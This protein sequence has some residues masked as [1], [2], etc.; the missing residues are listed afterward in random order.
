MLGRSSGLDEC[1][2]YCPKYPFSAAHGD[3]QLQF[4]PWVRLT[5]TTLNYL[6]T[7]FEIW[8]RNANSSLS[9]CYEKFLDSLIED[10]MSVIEASRIFL[11]KTITSFSKQIDSEEFALHNQISKCVTTQPRQAVKLVRNTHNHVTLFGQFYLCYG[12][13][14]SLLITRSGCRFESYQTRQCCGCH[15]VSG[16]LEMYSANCQSLA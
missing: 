16:T 8:L 6:V 7:H 11:M 10:G 5:C 2:Y 14:T 3:P 12:F 13:L 9:I 4:W 1:P 15:V